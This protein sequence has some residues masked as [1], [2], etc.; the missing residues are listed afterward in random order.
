[1]LGVGKGDISVC[2]RKQSRLKRSFTYISRMTKCSALPAI[3]FQEEFMK[4]G[5]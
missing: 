5:L 2:E 3:R 4:D 1:M